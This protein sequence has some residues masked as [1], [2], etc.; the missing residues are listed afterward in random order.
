MLSVCFVRLGNISQS[1]KTFKHK[2]MPTTKPAFA[3][4]FTINNPTN[5]EKDLVSLLELGK[6]GENTKA[7]KYLKFAL[8]HGEGETP[9][10]QG[11]IYLHTQQ[12]FSWVQKRLK[13]AAIFQTLGTVRQNVDY[14]GNPDFIHSDGNGEKAGKRKGGTS[15]PPV[16]WGDLDGVRT[17]KNPNK[18]NR[19][20]ELKQIKDEIDAGAK[21]IDLWENHFTAMCRY[22]R[23]IKEYRALKGLDTEYEQIK[24]EYAKLKVDK[25][26]EKMERRSLLEEMKRNVL[27][28]EILDEFIEAI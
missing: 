13:R 19:E 10:I 22:G 26:M 25:E 24:K 15:D 18:I 11:Y 27:N 17:D 5:E 12:R 21:E 4:C 9:H 2:Q 6:D 16:V 7:I 1:H 14:I 8:E 20:D 23:A 28:P 3:Y